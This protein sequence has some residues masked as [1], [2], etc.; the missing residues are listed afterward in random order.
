M[1]PGHLPGAA[2][3]YA[4]F[5]K[6]SHTVCAF[7]DGA[8]YRFFDNARLNPSTYTG[9]AEVAN[10]VARR[11]DTAICSDVADPLSL[12]QLEFHRT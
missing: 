3:R 6:K 9:Y 8:A 4:A 11:G 7:R 10:E 12:R 5:R 1:G 2:H